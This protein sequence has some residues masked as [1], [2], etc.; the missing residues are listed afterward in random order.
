MAQVLEVSADLV[1]TAGQG[2]R[3][4][5][6]VALEDREAAELGDGGGP[7][8]SRRAGN[9]M[10]DHSFFRWQTAHQREITLDDLVRREPLLHAPGGA[11]IERE[12]Q[13]T[14]GGPVE[15]VHC[16]NVPPYQ[17]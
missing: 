15:A 14:A 8:P 2:T 5:Q 4:D 6:G 13:S 11:G 16:V 12:Q 3:L 7:R 17:I 1:E 10:I 9:R